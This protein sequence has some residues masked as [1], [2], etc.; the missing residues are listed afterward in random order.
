MRRPLRDLVRFPTKKVNLMFTIKRVIATVIKIARRETKD[1]ITSADF[2]YCVQ[3]KQ[4][5]A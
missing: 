1:E 3:L 5:Y 2:V 4:F